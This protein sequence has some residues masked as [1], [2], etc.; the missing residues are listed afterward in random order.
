MIPIYLAEMSQLNRTYPEIWLE[1]SNGNRVVNKNTI[2]VCA[3]GPDHALEQLNRWMERTGGFVGITLNENARNQLISANLV[4]LT[5][6]ADE[7][8]RDSEAAK[9]TATMSCHRLF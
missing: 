7:M 3:I 2:S 8:I 1:F 6:E 4:W 5:E 9:K